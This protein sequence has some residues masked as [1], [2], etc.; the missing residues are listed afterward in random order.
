MIRLAHMLYDAGDVP[1]A[2]QHLNRVLELEPD[3]VEAREFIE[4]LFPGSGD[5]VND[6]RSLWDRLF[7][8]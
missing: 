3:H 1:E 5:R 7:G 6:Q 4:R 8:D 2:A